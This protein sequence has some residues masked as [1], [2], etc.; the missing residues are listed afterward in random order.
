[1]EISTNDVSPFTSGGITVDMATVGTAYTLGVDNVT[2]TSLPGLEQPQIIAVELNENQFI[3]SYP[4]LTNQ[5]YQLQFTTN[6][7][8]AT[9]VP[10]GLPVLGSGGF[11]TVSNA[12][13]ASPQGF[14]R[15]LIS[16]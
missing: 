11:V 3:F 6:L 12:L 13:P 7:V 8:P 16:P 2:V 15:L 10:L 14:F 5:Y 4:T 1:V 9:W